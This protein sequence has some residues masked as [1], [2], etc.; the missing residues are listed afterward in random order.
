MEF[1]PI[2]KIWRGNE[3]ELSA[4][5]K[6]QPALITNLSSKKGYQVVGEMV[7]DPLAQIW[8]GN[9]DALEAFK[10]QP[11]LISPWDTPSSDFGL[12]NKRF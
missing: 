12:F 7:F 3:K 8:I 9:E 10:S 6:K 2:L 11:K 4:F 5:S 1:D